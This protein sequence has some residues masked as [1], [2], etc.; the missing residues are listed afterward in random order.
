MGEAIL[1]QTKK[2]APTNY[3]NNGRYWL[4]SNITNEGFN[5]LYDNDTVVVAGS[6][7]G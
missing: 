6:D 2:E 1:K 5:F 4:K 7:S 3:P